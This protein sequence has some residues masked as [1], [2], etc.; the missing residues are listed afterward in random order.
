M[1]VTVHEEDKN[2]PS[3]FTQPLTASVIKEKER[4]VKEKAHAPGTSKIL[5][6]AREKTQKDGENKDTSVSFGM[7]TV[8]N[9]IFASVNRRKIP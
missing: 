1:P 6:K 4:Q 7:I 2:N 3:P 8:V 9:H 5:S